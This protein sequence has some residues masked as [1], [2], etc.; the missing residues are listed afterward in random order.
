VIALMLKFMKPLQSADILSELPTE[1]RVQVMQQFPRIKSVAPDELVSIEKNVRARVQELPKFILGAAN[2][3]IVFWTKILTHAKNQEEI[4]VDL[5]SN[6]P[7]LYEKLARFRF[8]LDDLTTLPLPLVTKVL[9]EIDNDDLTKAL[10]S[11]PGDIKDYVLSEV[12][13]KRQELLRDQLVS[14]A[15]LPTEVIQAARFKVTQK[16]REVMA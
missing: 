11:L 4:L 16:F 8:S 15:G 5:E 7:D 12:N 9:D 2:E 14:Y 3:D 10:L 1:L 6:R 13:P